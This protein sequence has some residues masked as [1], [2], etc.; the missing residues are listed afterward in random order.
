VRR[1]NHHRVAAVVFALA[2]ANLT[3]RSYAGE[4]IDTRQPCRYFYTSIEEAEK[5]ALANA[6]IVS[7]TN[8]EYSLS[9]P[10]NPVTHSPFPVVSFQVVSSQHQEFAAGERRFV[11]LSEESCSDVLDN[12]GHLRTG[13]WHFAIG[14]NGTEAG[15]VVGSPGRRT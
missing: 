15:R 3:T 9:P 1:L 8:I 13:E 4:G 7:G 12:A 11:R 2:A 14:I 5:S 6:R 10:R